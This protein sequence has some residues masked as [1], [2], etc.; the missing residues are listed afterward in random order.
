MAHQDRYKKFEQAMTALLLGNT[1]TFILY[2]IAAGAGIG[3]LKILSAALSL[4]IP[5]PGLGML[6]TSRE[7]T[8]PRSL[9]LGCGFF[10]LFCC[11]LASVIL[12]YPG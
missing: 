8:K 11:T 12:A 10:A 7:L 2:L 6:Y 9:W 1:F 3:W 5:V 4:V